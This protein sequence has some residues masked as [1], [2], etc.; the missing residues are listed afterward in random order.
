MMAQLLN[1]PN[2]GKPAGTCLASRVPYGQ[3]LTIEKI[4]RIAKAEGYIR[5]ITGVKVLRVRDHGDLARIEIV[6][7]ERRLFYNEELMGQIA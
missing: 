3:E 4:E 7:D 6:A 1:I 5:E 2:D